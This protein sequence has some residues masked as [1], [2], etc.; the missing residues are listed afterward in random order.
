MDAENMALQSDCFDYVFSWGVLHHSSDTLAAFREVSRILKTN[1]H[2]LIM[3]YNRS[4]LRYYLKGL[5]WLFA[6]GKVSEV[7][8]SLSAVQRF[9]TDGYYHRHFTPGE[10][11]KGLAE[12]GLRVSK[13]FPSHMTKRMI[14]G[15]PR[16]L[17]DFLKQKWGWLLVAE[18][19]KA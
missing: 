6:K 15:L 1:G 3:V 5:Y 4:S 7:G 18:V 9:Y 14:P 10:L 12:A 11:T 19:S 2:G 17:D 16:R 8:W 13:V